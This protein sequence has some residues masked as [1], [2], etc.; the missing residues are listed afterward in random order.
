MFV[1]NSLIIKKNEDQFGDEKSK[2]EKK[3]PPKIIFL[4]YLLQL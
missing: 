2:Q 4:N 1:A 3:K